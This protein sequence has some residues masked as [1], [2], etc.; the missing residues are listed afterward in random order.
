ML[1]YVIGK[2]GLLG[3]TRGLAAEW[4]ADGIRV[5]GVAPSLIETDMTSHLR[6]RVFKLEASRT[7]LRRL[8]QPED[9]AAAVSY[10][11]GKD[12]SFLTGVV[13]PVSGGQIMR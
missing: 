2:F 4:A 3:L 8:A 11:A 6:D 10:L 5:N 9:V 7:P 13:I 1:D 12:S